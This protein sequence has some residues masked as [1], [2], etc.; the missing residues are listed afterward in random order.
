MWSTVHPL[1]LLRSGPIEACARDATA[2]GSR[3]MS[4]GEEATRQVLRARLR[5]LVATARP[6]DRLPSERTL[7]QRWRAARMTVR[8]ATDALVAEG[9]VVR[10]HGSGTYVQSPPVIRFLGLTSFT[11]DMRARGLVAGSRLLD[12]AVGP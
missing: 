1:A 6:G 7:S 3:R 2:L 8:S 10:R 5:E 9:L 11:Q 4:N 12:F